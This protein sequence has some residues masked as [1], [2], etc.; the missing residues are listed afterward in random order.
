[1]VKNRFTTVLKFFKHYYAA[2][3]RYGVH[4]PYVYKLLTN[5]IDDKT[6]YPE[7]KIWEN[8]RKQLMSNHQFLEVDD[9]GAGSKVFDSGQR[10]VKDMARVAGSS[11]RKAKLLFRL[12]RYLQAKNILELGTHLGLGTMALALADKN[13]KV[14]TVDAD[15]NL[16]L[17]TRKQFK[18]HKINNV[19]WVPGSFDEVLPELTLN[20]K[21]D[22][23]FL[24][25]DHRG[26]ATLKYVEMLKPAMH[27]E[28]LLVLD[29]IHWSEDMEKAWMQLIKDDFFHVSLDLFFVGL[30]VPRPVQQKEHFIIRFL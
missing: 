3:N 27:E 8:F 25:G 19:K 26:D 23:I 5:C 28:T 29:D 10:R 6:R 17:F 16:M 22:L 4:S 2:K 14:T 13:A 7:Y 20:K 1:M 30:L 18:R 12:A 15:K 21:Y 9:R 24:D 11:K